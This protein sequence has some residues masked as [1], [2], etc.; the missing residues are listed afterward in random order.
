VTRRPLVAALVVAAV[1]AAMAHGA[2]VDRTS[3]RYTRDLTVPAHGPVLFVPDSAL[4]GH[5][6]VGLGDLRLV[7]A[8]GA[9]VPWRFFP[10]R[11]IGQRSVP[12]LNAGLEGGTA[13]ATLDLGPSG[14]LHDRVTLQIPARGFV[15]HA[16]VFGAE[17]RYGPRTR[18]GTTTMYDVSGPQHVR[19]TV[20]RFAPTDFRYLFLRIPGVPGIRGAIISVGGSVLPSVRRPARV[21]SRQVRRT[22]QLTLDFGYPHIPVSEIRLTSATPRYVRT[23]EEFFSSDGV[24][25]APGTVARV[26]SFPGAGVPGLSLDDRARFIRIV[27]HNGDDPPLRN[28]HATAYDLPRVVLAEGGHPGPYR[29]YYGSTTLPVPSYDFA[30]LPRSALQLSSAGKGRIGAEALN[31]AFRAAPD[32]RSFAAK[33]NWLVNGALALAALVVAAGG[34]VALRRR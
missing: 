19:S 25:Y 30:R 22:T 17:T 1:S 23:V 27:I 14:E 10:E 34:L 9:Q 11:A 20:A 3:F 7:D 32:T 15:A 2:D 8:T 16:T 18:L 5:A 13:V 4:L 6:R 21:T 31:S 29:L 33:H 26:S 24:H 28:L 12:L